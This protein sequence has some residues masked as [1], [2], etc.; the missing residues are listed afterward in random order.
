MSPADPDSMRILPASREESASHSRNRA[1]VEL[2]ASQWGVVQ[3]GQLLDLGFT[4]S[5]ISR[6]AALGWLRRLHQGV[7]ALGH[8]KLMPDGHR[9]AAVLS[10]GPRA[11]ASHVT[12]AAIWELRGESGGVRH[13]SV[14]APL[15]GA[16]STAKVRVHRPR[17][18]DP[19]E[20]T[21]RNGIP[22]TSLARTLVD[23]GDV[24]SAEQVRRAFI[25]AE[26]LRLIDMRQIEDALDR[27]RRRRGPSVLRGVLRAYDPRWQRTRSWLE[28]LALDL[29]RDHRLPQPEVNAWLAGR[30][31]ADLLWRDLRL[32]VEIDGGGVH[33]TPGARARDAVRDHALRRLGYDVVHVSEEQLVRPAAVAARIDRR[34]A[35]RSVRRT[36]I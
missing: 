22:V 7:F 19:R 21:V 27:T 25:R 4:R 15:S 6:L 10:A 34:L 33:G 13:V 14:P 5:A 23:L 2:A 16:R 31:E 29:V 30:W 12:A 20:C 3:A 36:A 17:V 11:V 9:L 24:V 8:D 1:L 35:A 26:Q 32:V 18:L 28:L